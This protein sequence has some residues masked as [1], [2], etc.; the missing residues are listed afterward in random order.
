MNDRRALDRRGFYIIA[1]L[2]SF[3]ILFSSLE[4]VLKVKDSQLFIEWH[5][6]M[7]PNEAVNED[8]FSIYLAGNVAEY[9]LKTAFPASIAITAYF[10]IGK[11]KVFG[12]MSF[13]WLVLSGGGFAFHLLQRD[14][15]SIFYYI[16]II[17]YTI[18][19]VKAS[20][21][22]LNRTDNSSEGGD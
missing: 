21:V 11:S 15:D 2:C 9:T 7:Y 14:F 18:L 1:V 16:G 12:A 13:I 6:D 4:A 8:N 20:V 22:A 17:L 5:K 19:I 3:L 10:S